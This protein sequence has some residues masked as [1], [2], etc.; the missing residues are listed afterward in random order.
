MLPT[1]RHPN[2][3]E[4]FVDYSSAF[5]WIAPLVSPCCLKLDD[6]LCVHLEPQSEELP[7]EG[8][9]GNGHF[10]SF[11]RSPVGSPGLSL[12]LIALATR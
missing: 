10:N 1:L 9:A 4:T 11:T 8:F 5:I 2:W 3:T 7:S 6:L 12:L